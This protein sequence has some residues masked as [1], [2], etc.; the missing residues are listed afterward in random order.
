MM[1]EYKNDSMDAR[2]TNLTF[3]E[4]KISVGASSAVL[5]NLP[6]TVRYAKINP[7]P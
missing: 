3:Y 5:T 2:E 1:K 7:S 6:Q 4:H